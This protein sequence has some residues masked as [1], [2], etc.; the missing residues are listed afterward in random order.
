ML[1]FRVLS[2][3][4][5]FRRLGDFRETQSIKK[6]G[7]FDAHLPTGGAGPSG[8]GAGAAGYLNRCVRD[9]GPVVLGSDALTRQ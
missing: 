1:V 5:A 8:P 2:L 4:P 9:H 6:S 7:S 3:T